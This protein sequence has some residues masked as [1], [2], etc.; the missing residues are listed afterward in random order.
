LSAPPEV[1]ALN[2]RRVRALV[3]K[4][5]VAAFTDEYAIGATSADR[6]RLR[7]IRHYAAEL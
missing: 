4:A 1:D 7:A 5:A 3:F 2:H 6:R